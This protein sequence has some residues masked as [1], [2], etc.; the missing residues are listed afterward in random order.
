MTARLLQI[1]LITSLLTRPMS[2]HAD[3]LSTVEEARALTFKEAAAGRTV[4]L[5]GIITYLRDAS[6]SQFNFNLNDSTGGVMVYPKLRVP[7]QTAQRVKIKGRTL[8]SIH[9]LRIQ[10][11][12]VEPGRIEVLPSPEP[13]SFESLVEHRSQ[14]R[15]VEI[16]A[17]LRCAR[18]ESPSIQPRRLALDFGTAK[19]RITAWVLH[20][21]TQSELYAPGTRLKIKGVPLHWT[22]GRGQMQSV[23]LMVDSTADIARIESPTYPR[24]QPVEDVL[25]WNT[26]SR[27][28]APITTAGTVTFV[29]PGE[30]IVIQEGAHALRVR[31][32]HSEPLGLSEPLAPL[33]QGDHIE[34]TG[35]PA[36]G[37]YT[38]ELEDA[39]FRPLGASTNF[40]PRDY[41]DPAAVLQ[42][43]GLVDRDAQ[44]IRVSGTV[45]DLRERDGCTAL[46]LTSG[47][48]TF[49]ALLP[50]E[51]PMSKGVRPG[52]VISVTGICTLGLSEERR[53][54]GRPPNEFT[55]Q[56]ANASQ[57]AVIKQAPWWNRKRLLIAA[58]TAVL[59]ALLSGLWALIAG[60]K[61]ANL[62]AEIKKRE[63]AE[64]RLTSDR[65]RLAGD[66][67]DTLEQT[68][69]AAGLQLAAAIRTLNSS[70]AASAAKLTL[71]NQLLARG[72]KEVRDAV[73]DLHVGESQAQSLGLLL[74]AACHEASAQGT[75]TI[76]YHGPEN[77]SATP[78]TVRSNVLRIA[79]E[80]LTNALKHSSA[81]V[82]EVRLEETPS[83]LQLSISD[84]GCGFNPAT[85]PG[86]ESGH[87][88]LSSIRERIQRLGGCFEVNTPDGGGAIITAKIPIHSP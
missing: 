62:R 3:P 52:A 4:E 81:T 86:P 28:E 58:S 26:T 5:E 35:Y 21:E 65:K 47:P 87:F 9:G 13:V 30:L 46:E 43:S 48:T 44:L 23:S 55:L 18:M 74:K 68:L 41:L 14:G 64:Q 2:S 76:A 40:L 54:L 60:R 56:L 79:Q 57:I 70:P 82:I 83:E 11:D 17:T 36:M 78:S 37:G 1:F 63:S 69:L 7:L 84:N 61:N 49:S 25:L 72:R 24:K 32:V 6:D 10:A 8:V 34:V 73:W 67:H 59:T 39:T 42:S 38:V 66:L 50:L 15:Y 33:K 12:T 71:A 31:P 45:T 22:N 53:R 77:D 27:P 19:D 51:E 16:E 88:G 20:F 85:T 29:R 80:S 75:A